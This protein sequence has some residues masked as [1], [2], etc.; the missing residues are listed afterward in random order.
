MK[1]YVQIWKISEPY[2][3]LR[4]ESKQRKKAEDKKEINFGDPYVKNQSPFFIFN[5]TNDKIYCDP[6]IIESDN[7]D[8]N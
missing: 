7:L 6:I 8:I 2:C 1:L 5:K 3:L 4:G